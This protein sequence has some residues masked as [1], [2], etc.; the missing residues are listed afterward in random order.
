MGTRARNSQ[1]VGR[2]EPFCSVFQTRMRHSV[3]ASECNDPS[4]QAACLLKQELA[5][6]RWFAGHCRRFI[7]RN[8]QPGCPPVEGTLVRASL[9]G[10]SPRGGKMKCTQKI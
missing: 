1:P 4:N 7:S 2:S 5:Q 8:P 9:A 10:A 3:G 6:T